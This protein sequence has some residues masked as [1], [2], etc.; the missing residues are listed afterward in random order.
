MEH[1]SSTIPDTSYKL[2]EWGPH[3]ANLTD[4]NFIDRAANQ[5][6]ENS[7]KDL[8]TDVEEAELAVDLSP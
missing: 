3:N 7:F 2:L 1:F 8:A 5:E 6:K 4:L